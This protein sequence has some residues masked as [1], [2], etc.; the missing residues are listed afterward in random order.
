MDIKKLFTNVPF[1]VLLGAVFLGGLMFLGDYRQVISNISSIPVATLLLVL[2]LTFLNYVLRA[3]KWHFL[4]S[5]V[6]VNIPFSESFKVFLAG[7]SMGITPAKAGEIL[8]PY[9]LKEKFNVDM[10]KTIPVVLA[11]RLSDVIGVG[12]LA[13]IGAASFVAYHGALFF[14]AVL[15]IAGI[16]VLNSRRFMRFALS[17]L[18]RVS[19]LKKYSEALE[20]S[21]ESLRSL[22]KPKPL[23][24]SSVLSVVSWFF[25]CLALFVLA[26][27]LNVN[28]PLLSAIFVFSFSSIFGAVFVL[29]GGLGV[30]EGSMLGLLLFSGVALG[31]A[32]TL[33]V[34]IRMATLWFGFLLGIA[35]LALFWKK[36][37]K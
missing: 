28:L 34:V 33:T 6:G 20:K 9:L 19:F 8:K 36:T 21:M 23:F 16:A 35:A 15:I 37:E 5:I 31:M 14:F 10:K 27:S 3:V 12:I 13:A 2:F 7:L 22:M 1:L 18:G 25:E 29:P 30:A 11:E 26:S 17:I 24:L 32:V 4:L